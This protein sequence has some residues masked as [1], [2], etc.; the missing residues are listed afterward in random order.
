MII[1]R[2][3]IEKLLDFANRPRFFFPYDMDNYLRDD[4]HRYSSSF[5]IVG[6]LVWPLSDNGEAF[7]RQKEASGN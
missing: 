4:I 6:N 1:R 5:D 7:Y 2:S 3:G